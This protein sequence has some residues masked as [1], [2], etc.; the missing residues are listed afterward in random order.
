MNPMAHAP[1]KI[2]KAGYK[3][4]C[5]A[6]DDLGVAQPSLFLDWPFPTPIEI[7]PHGCHYLGAHP[8]ELAAWAS[9]SDLGLQLYREILRTTEAL[10]PIPV[11]PQMWS[12]SRRPAHVIRSALQRFKDVGILREGKDLYWLQAIPTNWD[13]LTDGHIDGNPVKAKLGQVLALWGPM[14][15]VA[16]TR[17]AGLRNGILQGELWHWCQ[18]IMANTTLCPTRD[19]AQA[20]VAES[21]LNPALWE[22]VIDTFGPQFCI[23]WAR[24]WEAY[25]EEHQIQNPDGFIWKM[26]QKR[27]Y[28]LPAPK[29]T[30]NTAKTQSQGTVVKSQ[31]TGSQ[32]QGTGA[33]ISGDSCEISGDSFQG[34]RPYIENKRSPKR[35]GESSESCN[36]RGQVPAQLR[37]DDDMS[38]EQIAKDLRVRFLCGKSGVYKMLQ[39]VQDRTRL[40]LKLR[41]LDAYLETQNLPAIRNPGGFVLSQLAETPGAD[42][43]W[44]FAEQAEHTGT[45]VEATP[46]DLDRLQACGLGTADDNV[47]AIQMNDRF[48]MHYRRMDMVWTKE[49]VGQIRHDAKTTGEPSHT[50]SA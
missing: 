20:A 23:I 5:P 41:H 9:R 28:R 14:S 39:T 42:P 38:N 35:N 25:V 13:L 36:L 43:L 33:A 48:G 1:T 15:K 46:E 29:K 24:Q 40:D 32:S 8:G 11:D 49:L 18:R 22:Q 31:G 4:K 16:L 7:I 37:T 34:G 19:M 45:A 50:D 12:S 17:R 6:H 10:G 30:P 2:K 47:V 27:D 44:D 26:I 21:G 3:A